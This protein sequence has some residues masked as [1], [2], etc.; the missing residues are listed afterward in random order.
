MAAYLA[1][2][3]KDIWFPSS[4]DLSDVPPFVR[5]LST[6]ENPDLKTSID[7]STSCPVFQ[8]TG[9][10]KHGLK[11]RFLGGHAQI[12][13]SGAL[14]L[15]RD[16][17]KEAHTAVSSK[18]VNFVGPEVLAQLSKHKVSGTTTARKTSDLLYRSILI[19]WPTLI[20]KKCR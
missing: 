5:S 8:E 4:S 19:H 1:A 17:D 10:C 6:P 12:S 15:L 2:K 14:M 3:P 11:C 16:E 7:T 9:W 18:E 13:E 20:S